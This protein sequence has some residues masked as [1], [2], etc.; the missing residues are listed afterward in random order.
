[1]DEENSDRA[2]LGGGHHDFGLGQV[3]LEVFEV[4]GEMSRGLLATRTAG[5]GWAG[6][7]PLA[8]KQ[9][10]LME[11]VPCTAMMALGT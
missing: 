9:G 8:R 1:M 10:I 2:G 6:N 7:A 3:Q 4:P 11:G 5:V